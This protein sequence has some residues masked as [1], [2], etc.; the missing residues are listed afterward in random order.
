MCIPLYSILPVLV[1]FFKRIYEWIKERTVGGEKKLKEEDAEVS[2]LG[3]KETT[4]TLRR[5]GKYE[6]TTQGGV[7]TVSSLDQ[8]TEL[9]ETNIVVVKFTAT[10]CR[11]CQKIS[12]FFNS[13]SHKIRHCRFV[14]LDV[15]QMDEIAGNCNVRMMPTFQIYREGTKV[16]EMSGIDEEKLERIVRES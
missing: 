12:P 4:D 7:L 16:A 2:T 11:P 3:E 8:W 9:M 1:L 15:D 6:K 5:R 10:W 13:L 14:E